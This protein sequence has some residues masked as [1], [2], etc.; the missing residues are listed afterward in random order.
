[1]DGSAPFYSATL[2]G[3]RR[4]FGRSARDIDGWIA[5]Q[6][7]DCRR[8]HILCVRISG[9]KGTVERRTSGHPG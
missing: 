7:A 1:M 4:V 2:C 8:P 9:S 6:W 5:E 3:P